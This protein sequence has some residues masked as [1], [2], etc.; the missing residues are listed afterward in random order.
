MS[1]RRLTYRNERGK[2]REDALTQ[3]SGYAK[4]LTELR[5]EAVET[6]QG[7]ASDYVAGQASAY[8]LALDA[9][10]AWSEGRFGQSLD[11]QRAQA[12]DQKAA[13]R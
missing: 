8:H 2:G 9:L 12:E 11:E 10:H 3:L 1:D 5:D 4:R 6:L 13:T 7:N